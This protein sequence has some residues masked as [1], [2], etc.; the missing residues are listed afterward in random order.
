MHCKAG[1]GRRHGDSGVKVEKS[2]R[3]KESYLRGATSMPW[4]LICQ[5]MPPEFLDE[6]AEGM[7]E[8][9]RGMGEIEE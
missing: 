1:C 3:T 9:K 4:L 5:G 7:G 2:E 6:L 8:A